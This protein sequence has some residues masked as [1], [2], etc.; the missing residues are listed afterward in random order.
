[1]ENP[2]SK[3]LGTVPLT[4]LRKP[5]DEELTQEQE[6]KKKSKKGI[7]AVISI[8]AVIAIITLVTVLVMIFTEPPEPP[9]PFDTVEYFAAAYNNHDYDKIIDCFDPRLTKAFKN[10]ANGVA[11]FFGLPPIGSAAVSLVGNFLGGF[12]KDFLAEQDITGT[13]TVREISTVLDGDDK[14]TVVAEFTVTR[15]SGESD[16]WEQ[17]INMVKVDGV[18]YFVFEWAWLTNLF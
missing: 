6:P 18:W 10:I 9:K 12:A 3:S 4:Q 11:G 7:I 13:M 17:T 2:E 16:T 14:A 1:M 5:M 15:S 8:A